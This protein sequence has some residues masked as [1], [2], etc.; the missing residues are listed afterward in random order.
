MLMGVSAEQ[1][2]L[3][4]SVR[5]F[6]AD[7]APLPRSRCT[8]PATESTTASSATLAGCTAGAGGCSSGSGAGGGS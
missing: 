8:G 6:L 2:E 1:Q 3:R 7:Q 4:E 5:R